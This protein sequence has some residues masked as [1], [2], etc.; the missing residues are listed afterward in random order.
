MKNTGT[1]SENIFAEVA[2]N[3]ENQVREYLDIKST[4]I[5]L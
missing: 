3:L 2:I 1:I 5:K 4:Y